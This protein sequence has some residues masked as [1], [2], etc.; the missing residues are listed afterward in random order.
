[1]TW[2]EA[3]LVA[4]EFAKVT[5]RRYA[6]KSDVRIVGLRVI[7]WRWSVAPIGWERWRP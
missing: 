3:M 7:G 4:N 1:M 2:Q 6:V 5:G